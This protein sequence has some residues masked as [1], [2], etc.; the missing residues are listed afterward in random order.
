MSKRKADDLYEKIIIFGKKGKK[1]NKKEKEEEQ[2]C[3]L[4]DSKMTDQSVT[5]THPF[6]IGHIRRSGWYASV[7]DRN[8]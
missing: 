2:D 5:H 1:E 8:T 3:L 7:N 6:K 4:H